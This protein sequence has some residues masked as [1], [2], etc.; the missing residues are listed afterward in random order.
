M[1]STSF[2][3]RCIVRAL[4]END[5]VTLCTC[6]RVTRGPGGTISEIAISP[7]LGVTTF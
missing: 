5:V 1:L 6:F 3:L 7:Y 4:L 2:L